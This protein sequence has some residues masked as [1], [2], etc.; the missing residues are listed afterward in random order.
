MQTL[1]GTGSLSSSKIASSSRRPP[2]EGRHVVAQRRRSV[3]DDEVAIAEHAEA[4][5]HRCRP[6][7]KLA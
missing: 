1:I 5:R 4:L 6:P 7:C 3:T 2:R